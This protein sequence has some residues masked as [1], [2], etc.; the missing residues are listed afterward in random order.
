MAGRITD[1]EFKERLGAEL[2]VR[3]KRC[4]LTTQYQVKAAAESALCARFPAGSGVIVEHQLAEVMG[5]FEIYRDR[6][7]RNGPG[8]LTGEPTGAYS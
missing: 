3:Y 2:A 5:H 7:R 8:D 6:L 1:R 4:L